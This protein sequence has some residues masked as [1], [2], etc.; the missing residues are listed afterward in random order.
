MNSERSRVVIDNVYPEFDC[1]RVAI[2]R[3]PGEEVAVEA[4]IYADG[5]DT[6][7]CAV[8]YRNESE[9]DWKAQLMSRLAND[10]WR[11]VFTVGEI[12][13]YRYTIQG[14][15]DPF[16]T[17]RNDLRKRISADQDTHL[18]YLSGAQLLDECI[19][20]SDS[21]PELKVWADLLRDESVEVERKRET[22]LDELLEQWMRDLLDRRHASTY[23]HELAV[24]VDRERARFSSWYELFPRSCSDT[25]GAHGTFKDC[26]RKLHYVASMGFDTLYLPPIHPIGRTHRKG[27]NN[28]TANQPDDV[29][30]PW[31]IGSPGGGHTAIHP[32]LG[33]AKD[34]RRLIAAAKEFGIELALDIAFQCSP[35]HPW[36][37]EHP[38]WFKKRPDGSIQYAENPPKKYQDIYPIDFETDDWQRLWEAL[39]NVILHWCKEGIR[40]YR[41]DNPHTKAFSFWEWVIREVKE[42]YPE[43]I[44]LAE[45]FT[46]P[47]VMYRLAKLGFTQSYSYFTWRNTKQELTDYMTQL[48]QTEVQE[49]FRPNLWPNTPDILP[50]YLQFGGRPAFITRL[51]LAA[52]LS[53]NY[54][55]YGPAFELGENTP[56][57]PGSEEYLDSEKYEIRTW[58]LDRPDSLKEFIAR[59]NG[60]RRTNSALQST[61]NLHF[62]RSDNDQL[63][64]YSK[65][66]TDLS[67]IVLVV[68]NLDPHHR[69]S[70]YLDLDLKELGLDA[71]RSYQAHDLLTEARYL[72]QGSRNYVELAPHSNPAHVLV[73]RRR[74]RT[75]R[76]FD[77]FM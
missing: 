38:E 50:E 27:P 54:G 75:E 64:C 23:Q 6:I 37:H 77:Y 18:D 40:I 57:K 71:T 11:G 33:T 22:A 32:E 8:L 14:W 24:Q 17:W 72:W 28:T 41:V 19:K 68:V 30:S 9:T 62:H 47:S 48:T 67:N 69:Q 46:R 61:R 4:D 3:T 7:A 31:A 66:T 52:T 10:R 76:H 36:V 73:I 63:L 55:I 43:T 20:K 53:G 29:G 15:I 5:H 25:P 58:D 13:R 26:E 1:G 74:V 56:L 39:K 70:G 21:P 12:G 35:D 34:F 59:V 51:V 45:A 60:I 44:F 49:Y 65:R 2:K 42:L 16:Q